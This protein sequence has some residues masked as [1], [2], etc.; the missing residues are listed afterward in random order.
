[1]KATIEKGEER[2]KREEEGR[3]G[4]KREEE[5]RRGKKKVTHTQ[6]KL[7]IW[8]SSFFDGHLKLLNCSF[9]FFS[10]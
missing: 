6:I 9:I 7:R 4:K 10:C 2:K 1:M 3:R 8:I 5:G